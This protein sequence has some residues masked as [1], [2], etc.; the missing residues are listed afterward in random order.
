LLLAGACQPRAVGPAAPAVDGVRAYMAALKSSDSSDAYQMMSAEAKKR[1]SPAEFALQWKQSE[2]ERTWQITALEKSI[3]GNPNVGERAVVRFSDGKLVELERDGAAW[4]LDS[5]RVARSRAKQPQDAIR[6][7]ADAIAARDVTAILGVLT[8]R[9]RDGLTKQIE[10]FMS[11]LGK[12][13]N[14]HLDQFSDRAEL[15]W[16]DNGLRYRIILRNEEGEWR[17]DDISIRPSP[18]DDEPTDKPGVE[19][20]LPEDF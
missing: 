16:D 7:F 2:K 6:L 11:G 9:R 17:V 10:G 4:R 18:K 1:I 14:D 19:G 20:A 12:R 13:L 5:D 3:G 15:R 8:Q